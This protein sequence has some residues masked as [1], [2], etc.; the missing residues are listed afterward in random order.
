MN[1]MGK[2]GKHVEG[3]LASEPW[4]SRIEEK[5]VGIEKG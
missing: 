3:R 1:S 5:A 2:R 4:T